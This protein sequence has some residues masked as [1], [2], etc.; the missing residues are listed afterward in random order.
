MTKKEW[1]EKP[2]GQKHEAFHGKDDE[3]FGPA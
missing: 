1:K 2:E 3:A